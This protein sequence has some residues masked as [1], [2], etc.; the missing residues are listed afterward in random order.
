MVLYISDGQHKENNGQV[1]EE[2]PV[3]IGQWTRFK[4]ALTLASPPTVTLTA[5]G[6]PLADEKV[7]IPPAAN[8]FTLTIGPN[9]L[10]AHTKSFH[11]DF[12]AFRI[13]VQ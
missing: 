3:K 10:D 12:D 9:Y 11:V 6:Q 5:D 13:D 1:G 4:L 2:L 7:A 8:H